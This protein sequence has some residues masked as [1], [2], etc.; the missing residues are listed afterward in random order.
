MTGL[1]YPTVTRAVAGNDSGLGR[2]TGNQNKTNQLGD[3]SV[4]CHPI[5]MAP[6]L[7]PT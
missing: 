4:D 7:I 1:A 2:R 6:V 5:V 3:G